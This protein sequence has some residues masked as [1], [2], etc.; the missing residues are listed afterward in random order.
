MF[1]AASTVVGVS[2]ALT[3]ATEASFAME[4]EAVVLR[5]LALFTMSSGW[6]GKVGRAFGCVGEDPIISFFS[7]SVSEST[8][9]MPPL[10]T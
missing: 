4:R 3:I 7:Q 8:T 5:R 6:S 9:N 2:G 1:A 10:S